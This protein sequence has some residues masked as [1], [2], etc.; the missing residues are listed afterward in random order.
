MR[1]NLQIG[2]VGTVS[3]TLPKLNC[4]CLLGLVLALVELSARREGALD[5][6]QPELSEVVRAA[7][8]SA[9]LHT[10]PV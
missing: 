1:R 2:V 7:R 4:L 9:V 8:W 3:K 6:L 5:G 10:V